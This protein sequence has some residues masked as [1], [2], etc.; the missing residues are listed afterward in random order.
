MVSASESTGMQVNIFVSCR[1]LRKLD[2]FSDSDPTCFMYLF[3]QVSQK[4]V[5]QGHTEQIMNSEVVPNKHYRISSS[6]EKEWKLSSK[7]S[8]LNHYCLFRLSFFQTVVI[9]F[10]IS[11]KS[12]STR[13][14]VEQSRNTRR[15]S[16]RSKQSSSARNSQLNSKQQSTLTENS[17]LVE[18]IEL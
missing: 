14:S 3:N 13:A 2:T 16:Q 4:W 11:R 18:N 8:K 17:T 7:A 15:F 5:K 10:C 1:K 12:D 6:T 9:I